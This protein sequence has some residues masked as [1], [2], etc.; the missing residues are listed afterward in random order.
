MREREPHRASN[1]LKFH[2]AKGKAFGHSAPFLHSVLMC[3]PNQYSF[4][5]FGSVSADHNRS[6]V[7]RMKMTYTN[8]LSDDWLTIPFPPDSSSVSKAPSAG[9]ARTCESSVRRFR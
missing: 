5:C 8:L 3:I 6:G 2:G 4:I 1:R 9:D 7:V